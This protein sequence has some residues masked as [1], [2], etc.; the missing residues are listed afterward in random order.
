MTHPTAVP[1]L[2]RWKTF[3]V[4]AI[5]AAASLA[6]TGAA[7]AA[8]IVV[9]PDGS[10][11]TDNISTAIT[12][13]NT[14]TDSSNTLV[15]Q[16]G[17]Y[18]PK[19][20]ATEPAI[21]KN[22]AIVGNHANQTATVLPSVQIAGANQASITPGNLFTINAGVTVDI[23]GVQIISGGGAGFNQID[24]SGTLTL[25]GDSLTGAPGG[26]IT[27]E[28]G[29]TLNFNESTLGSMSQVGITNN[30][31]L[32]L[33][34][35]DVVSGSSNN[36]VNSG[37]ETMNNTLV[38]KGPSGT[39]RCVGTAPTNGGTGSMDDD[40]TCGVAN[41]NNSTVDSF[42]PLSPTH[43]GGP[44]ETWKMTAGSPTVGA[45]TNCQTTDQRF[46]VNPVSGGVTSCD[47]GAVTNAAAR[48]TTAP[49]CVVTGSSGGPPATQ[50]VTVQSPSGMGPESGSGFGD[51]NE[52]SASSPQNPRS[53]AS[54]NNPADAIDGLGITNGTISS[55]TP[56]TAPSTNGLTITA[57]KTTAGT[58]TH[59][60]F[61]A[62]DW[63]GNVTFCQ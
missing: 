29:A 38:I 6:F 63:A 2:A 52:F 58:L 12:Q 25:W 36:I 47:I 24:N 51:P 33:D 3:G 46:F 19:S 5:A 49:T 17:K 22:L 8:V 23:E 15:L 35:A 53:L 30:G 26:G 48:N 55:F 34:T 27:N 45:G 9:N 37:T 7:S 1:R 16:P 31:T 56:F 39:P 59:W 18:T 11:G 62:N 40:G 60:W 54:P 14:N 32:S 28:T 13:A 44:T 43:N 50:T 4:A 57:Q 41:S 21:N 10:A 20:T 61:T 42:L